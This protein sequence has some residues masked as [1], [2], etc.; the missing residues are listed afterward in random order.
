VLDLQPLSPREPLEPDYLIVF[1]EINFQTGIFK[2]RLEIL[3]HELQSD[4]NIQ[5]QNFS[6]QFK[7]AIDLLSTADRRYVADFYIVGQDKTSYIPKYESAI[8]VQDLV[9]QWRYFELDTIFHLT[10]LS[11]KENTRWLHFVLTNSPNQFQSANLLLPRM[12]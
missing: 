8:H 4:L 10:R 7:D 1:K 12:R 11:W 2:E 3:I 6:V 5:V 9:K